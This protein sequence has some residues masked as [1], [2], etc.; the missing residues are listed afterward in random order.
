LFE[1]K[2]P[3][4]NVATDYKTD[5]RTCHVPAKKYDWVG[6]SQAQNPDQT[7]GACWL[8]GHVAVFSPFPDEVAN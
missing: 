6:G 5:C 1:A 2:D 8:D 3:K 7:P 4:K